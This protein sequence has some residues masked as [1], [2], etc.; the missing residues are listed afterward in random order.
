MYGRRFISMPPR[1]MASRKLLVKL[2]REIKQCVRG[3]GTRSRRPETGGATLTRVLESEI[4]NHEKTDESGDTDNESEADDNYA[5]DVA[6][7]E[8]SQKE[9]GA[10]SISTQ[11]MGR[12]KK[13]G[14]MMIIS[15]RGIKFW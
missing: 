3:D 14:G 8:H 13:R 10:S 9:N 1:K 11:E 12:G 15:S 5:P 4:D 7:A 6:A 2:D